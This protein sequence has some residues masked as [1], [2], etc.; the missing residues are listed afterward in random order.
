MVLNDPVEGAKIYFMKKSTFII[1]VWAI[2]ALGKN[3]S[4]Q[5]VA[6][7]QIAVAPPALP[8]Y[9]Q[10]PCPVEGYLWSPGYWA[11]AGGDYYWVPGVW[12]LPPQSGFLWTPGYWG[13]AGGYYG[14]H[15]G[16]WG[17]HVG[18]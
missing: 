6:S 17:A 11:Y 18:F 14:W 7:V 3:A 1:V 5:I 12:I 16:Y 9:E 2:M 10:P 13:F 15:A 4:G 8:V